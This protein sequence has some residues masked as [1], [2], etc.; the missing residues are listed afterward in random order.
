MRNGVVMTAPQGFSDIKTTHL[1]CRALTHPFDPVQTVVETID[2]RRAYVVQL[3]CLRCKTPAVD[4]VFVASGEK[5]PRRY[6]YVDG[7]LIKDRAKWGD[8]KTFNAN[9]RLELYGRLAKNGR[10]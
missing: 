3:L 6:G 5:L 10:K 7:Y 4:V 1:K 2:R 9:V 8:A